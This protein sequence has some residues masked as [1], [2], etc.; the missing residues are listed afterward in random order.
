MFVIFAENP[1]GE[2]QVSIR[3]IPQS[4]AANAQPK[5]FGKDQT[6]H[7]ADEIILIYAAFSVLMNMRHAPPSRLCEVLHELIVSS[8][9]MVV[10][11][12]AAILQMLHLIRS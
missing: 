8:S 6:P 7:S 4:T 2:G 11:A 10:S 5:D 3:E 1:T 12:Q 9:P